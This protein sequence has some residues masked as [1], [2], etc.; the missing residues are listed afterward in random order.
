M[1]LDIR[2]VPSRLLEVLVTILTPY[3]PSEVLPGL[4]V[5]SKS[6]EACVPQPNHFLTDLPVCAGFGW[7][8]DVCVRSEHRS[9]R[10]QGFGALSH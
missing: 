1:L 5:S 4:T 2:E 7:G 10:P 6:T 8:D 3:K 9:V